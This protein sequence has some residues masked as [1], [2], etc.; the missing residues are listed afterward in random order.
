MTSTTPTLRWP[1]MLTALLVVATL[2]ALP[3]PA[4]AAD[5]EVS[6]LPDGLIAKMARMRARSGELSDGKA[7]DSADA[8]RR[9][10]PQAPCGSINIG[11]VQTGRAGT[12]APKEVI[13]VIKGDVVNANNKCR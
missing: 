7:G 12:R 4:R 11:N 9:A 1:S 13:V 5:D 3:C 2:S 6:E 10:D 8:R